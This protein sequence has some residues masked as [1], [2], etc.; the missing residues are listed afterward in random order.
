[1]ELIAGVDGADAIVAV[2]SCPRGGELKEDGLASDDD[3]A[4]LVVAALL[5]GRVVSFADD[6]DIAGAVDLLPCNMSR[7]VGAEFGRIGDSSAI[8]LEQKAAACTE[9][10]PPPPA[11]AGSMGRNVCWFVCGGGVVD[12]EAS[13]DSADEG[14]EGLEVDDIGGVRFSFAAAVSASSPKPL[15]LSS[16]ALA[17]A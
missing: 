12:G 14:G 10:S 4:T 6:D 3:V 9:S 7:I 8:F 13:T 15:L 1:M 2:A 16:A 11:A 5:C 17:A